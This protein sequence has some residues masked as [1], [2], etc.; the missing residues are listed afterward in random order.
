[1]KKRLFSTALCVVMSAALCACSETKPTDKNMTPTPVEA[2]A[3][4]AATATPSVIQE[5]EEAL[6]ITNYDDY[7]ASTILPDGYASIE[8]VKVTDADVE[9]YI[10]EVLENNKDRE[11]K[12]GPIENGDIAIIDYTGYL[13]GETFEGG[14]AVGYEM[15]VGHSGF[16]DGFDDGLIGAKKKD[17]VTLNLKFPSDY[18]AADLAGKDVVFEVKI[19]SVAAQVLPEFTDEF[20]TELTSGQYTTTED[21]RLYSK[22]FLSEEK[23]YTAVMDYLVENATFGKLNEEYIKASFE[24]EKEYYAL[25]YVNGTV[26]QFEE[27][28]G[29]E[30][31]EILWTMVEQ[32][33]RR[34]EQDRVAL[35]SVAKAEN[36]TVS[37]E[38]FNATATEYAESMGMTLDEVLEV[39]DE[40]SLR[41]SIMMEAALEFLLENVV[42]VEKGEE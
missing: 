37:D 19:N 22:G 2:T 41:Q 15:E 26:E 39:Q 8:V 12:D 38:E 32:E 3:T 13:N 23:R 30:N 10:Q 1:M 25:M 40:A 29:K 9:A 4:P 6:P 16:I 11:L 36:I 35:Y 27:A 28:F 14:S 17:T 21:F 18:H 33:I 24:L 42:E 34:Y 31:S 20:V 7:V 5:M